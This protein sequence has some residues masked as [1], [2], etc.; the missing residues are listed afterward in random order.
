MQRVTVGCWICVGALVSIGFSPGVVAAQDSTSAALAE[1]LAGLMASGQLEALASKD[2]VDEDRFVAALAFP[3]QLLVVSA[4]YEVPIA[5][6]Q[7]IA[8]GQYRDVYIDLNTRSIAGTR[9]LIT[10]SGA[11]G[12]RGED[13]TVDVV[14]N[15]GQI[16]LLDGNGNGGQMSNDEYQGAVAEVDSQYSRMLSALIAQVE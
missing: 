3:G 1:E 6:E 12:L 11:N 2:T 15:A 4:R 8:S 5:V 7:K 10:D 14:D 13:S 9:T 16:L